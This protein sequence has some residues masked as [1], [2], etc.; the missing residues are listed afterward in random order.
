[1]NNQY[2]SF[3]REDLKKRDN[4]YETVWIEIKNNKSKNIIC[5]CI[6]RHPRY[7]KSGFQ[8]YMIL[9]KK[10]TLKIKRFT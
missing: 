1:M 8:Q 6:Y 3:E 5:G 4:D 7:D 2:N 9:L 10:L